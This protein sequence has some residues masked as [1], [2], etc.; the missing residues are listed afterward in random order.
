MKKLGAFVLAVR[1]VLVLWNSGVLKDERVLD[2]LEKGLRGAMS[3]LERGVN[4]LV[5]KFT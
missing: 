2:A 4:F 5:E 3:L 1:L